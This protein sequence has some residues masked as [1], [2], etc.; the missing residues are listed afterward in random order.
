M[1][2]GA[3][4][5]QIGCKPLLVI[6]NDLLES[7]LAETPLVKGP[8]VAAM[9]VDQGGMLRPQ[10]LGETQGRVKTTDGCL[11]SHLVDALAL[12]VRQH[13]MRRLQQIRQG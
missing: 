5:E 3:Q 13:Q 7:I 12:D 6:Q 2:G 9:M 1:K 10:P 8:F 4:S 11:G